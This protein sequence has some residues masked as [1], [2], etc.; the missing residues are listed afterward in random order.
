MVVGGAV[1]MSKNLQAA[2]GAP[3]KPEE[4]LFQAGA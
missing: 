2:M 4:Q 1:G 3:V